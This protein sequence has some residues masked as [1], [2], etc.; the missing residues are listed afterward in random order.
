MTQNTR[1]RKK[2]FQSL[3][4]DLE[5]IGSVHTELNTLGNAREITTVSTGDEFQS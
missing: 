2:N 4:E 3:L 1:G 5:S